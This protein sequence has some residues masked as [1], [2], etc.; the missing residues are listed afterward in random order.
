MKS[1]HGRRIERLEVSLPHRAIVPG[2]LTELKGFDAPS[3]Y[4]KWALEDW[5]AR[6]PVPRLLNEALE[7]HQD[8]GNGSGDELPAGLSSTMSAVKFHQ[9]LLWEANIEADE[10]VSRCRAWLETATAIISLLELVSFS[11]LGQK[12]N[13]FPVLQC[14]NQETDGAEPTH[15]AAEN[16]A[17]ERIRDHLRKAG[18]IT[19]D[20][21]SH[22]WACKLASERISEKHFQGAEILSRSINQ[23]MEQL[24]EAAS[25]S[26]ERYGRLLHRITQER[27]WFSEHLGESNEINFKKLEEI[28]QHTSMATADNLVT[29]AHSIM[30]ASFGEQAHNG[31]T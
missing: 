19:S 5:S 20:V 2:W 16:H 9:T 8:E 4:L 29:Y 11:G 26:A 27:T 24:S 10:T 13:A 7:V 22:L 31:V 28:A 1:N 14:L 18:I 17:L 30:L 3:D 6:A 21:L 23:A 15:G 25:L 12:T